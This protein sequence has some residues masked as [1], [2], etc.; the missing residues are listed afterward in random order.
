VQ[1]NVN[2]CRVPAD[3]H[4]CGAAEWDWTVRVD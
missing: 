3:V 1:G 2:R 4:S